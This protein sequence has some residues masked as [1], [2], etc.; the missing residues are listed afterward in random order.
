[1]HQT[2]EGVSHTNTPGLY[3]AFFYSRQE[4]GDRTYGI[5][6]AEFSG[7]FEGIPARSAVRQCL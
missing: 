7:C 1:M 6:G 2:P 5:W 3:R 4:D